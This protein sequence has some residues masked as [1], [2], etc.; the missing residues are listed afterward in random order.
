MGSLASKINDSFT[1]SPSS[2]PSDT[3]DPLPPSSPN[4]S[5]NSTKNQQPQIPPQ[6]GDP[7]S[8]NPEVVR[9]CTKRYER[10]VSD[11][12]QPEKE[13]Y[14]GEISLQVV[15]PVW[16]SEQLFD[17]QKDNLVIKLLLIPIAPS[18]FAQITKITGSTYGYLHTGIQI[19]NKVVDWDL[20]G[21]VIPR[22]FSSTVY[23]ALDITSA[24]TSSLK[25]TPELMVK[26]TQFI[27]KWNSSYEYQ[28]FTRNC[29]H[30]VNELLEEIGINLLW[31]DS[32]ADYINEIKVNPQ[33]ISPHIK[34]NLNGK[35]V[36]KDFKNHE[37]LDNFIIEFRNND[38]DQYSNLKSLLKAFD[39][40][41]WFR[42]RAAKTFI[43]PPNCP[44]DS[45]TGY[46]V[47]EFDNSLL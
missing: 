33:N 45:P 13:R 8:P 40:G 9:K 4:T 25:K 38:P 22:Q 34:Y 30:F 5:S 27:A 20:T 35:K 44:F 17:P 36:R 28:T 12:S 19:N 18:A 3:D 37:D 46:D 11:L 1:L 14:F 10:R 23:A 16:I 32:I 41:F 26:V 6:P 47:V 7:T 2:A 29:Q 21:L 42:D 15:D 39:R 43:A 31:N 24:G